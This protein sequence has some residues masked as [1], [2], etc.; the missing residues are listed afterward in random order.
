MD[1]NAH[2]LDFLL[3]PHV[4]RFIRTHERLG[5]PRFPG[6]HFR[7]GGR[8]WVGVGLRIPQG[9]K[10]LLCSERV[11]YQWSRPLPKAP[12]FVAINIPA[13]AR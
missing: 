6:I 7:A 2:T 3:S 5:T 11:Q 9:H 10:E 1:A 8:L 13:P 12:A 4:W